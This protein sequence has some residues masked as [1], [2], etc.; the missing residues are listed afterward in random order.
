MMKQGLCTLRDS[1]RGLHSSMSCNCSCEVC[2]P[3]SEKCEAHSHV[4]DSLTDM[5]NA[6]VC[7]KEE[8]DKWHRLD[9][10]MGRCPDCGVTKFDFCPYEL[11]MCANQKLKWKCFDKLTVGVDEESGQE[12]KRIQE[13]FKE[14]SPG[15]FV[16]YLKTKVGA[17]VT[18]NFVA[19]WQDFE[20]RKMMD[21]LPC[22]VLISHI[23]FAENYSFA[24]QNEVQ[25]MHWFSTSITIL[26]HITLCKIPA[27]VD[28]EE[29]GIVK[30]YTLLYK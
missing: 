16:A 15:E 22:G 28:G 3:D 29:G 27:G 7:A 1:Q 26:V 14:T 10:L 6:C 17:F 9:C 24:I 11:S 4:H 5:W 20:C 30:T 25:S 8:L 23:D 13:V 2:G 12:K 21:N 18:H 19:N